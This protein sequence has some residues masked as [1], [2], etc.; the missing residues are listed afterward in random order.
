MKTAPLLKSPVEMRL[1][2]TEI[3]YNKSAARLLN[4]VCVNKGGFFKEVQWVLVGQRAA[5]LPAIKVGGQKEILPN[6]PVR[7]RFARTGPIG[8]FFFQTSNFDS[9]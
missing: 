5:K 3:K 8:R 7:I 1:F 4:R 9:W 2:Q 6:G